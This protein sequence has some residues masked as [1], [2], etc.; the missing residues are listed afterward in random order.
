MATISIP[1]VNFLIKQHL[2]HL[3][4]TINVA[5]RKEG[6]YSVDDVHFGY[7]AD[8]QRIYAH[9]HFTGK[10][11]SPQECAN[12]VLDYIKRTNWT[13]LLGPGLEQFKPVDVPTK[14]TDFL[15]QSTI[16]N[17][18]YDE[19]ECG[20]G[21]CI[22]YE[23]TAK[24]LREVQ[25]YFRDQ[26]K[27]NLKAVNNYSAV[28]IKTDSFDAVTAT[29]NFVTKELTYTQYSP[30]T[31]QDPKA[32]LLDNL[33]SV[34]RSSMNKAV[35]ILNSRYTNTSEV[36]RTYTYTDATLH[37][38]ID[39]HA[40]IK[41][42]VQYQKRT[43]ELTANLLEPIIKGKDHSE[44]LL[45]DLDL[46]VALFSHANMT[47]L[48]R[49]IKRSLLRGVEILAIKSERIKGKVRLAEYSRYGEIVLMAPMS[50]FNGP[51]VLV[52]IKRAGG[53]SITTPLGE[54]LN[55]VTVEKHMKKFESFRGDLFANDREYAKSILLNKSV[56]SNA[57]KALIYFL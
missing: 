31:V 33:G 30:V 37:Q 42:V 25:K 23:I 57:Y 2:A 5:L 3:Q 54:P 13:T 55:L 56:I 1:H 17:W 18:D 43:Y 20:C 16:D 24:G 10:R 52:R 26:F 40:G 46:S 6:R 15:S 19:V 29:Y 9:V 12:I 11:E 51:I 39:Y 45:S 50:D 48:K 34:V 41:I 14:T 21:A 7:D 44:V 4:G 8:N 27:A 47:E 49:Q 36:Q 53:I 35:S 38:A 32:L 22:T 28:Q